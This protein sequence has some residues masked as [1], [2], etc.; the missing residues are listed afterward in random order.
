MSAAPKPSRAKLTHALPREYRTRLKTARFQFWT[1]AANKAI[2]IEANIGFRPVLRIC[3]DGLWRLDMTG[4]P[5]SGTVTIRT[6]AENG[7]DKRDAALTLDLDSYDCVIATDGATFRDGASWAFVTSHGFYDA[8]V[9]YQQCQTDNGQA[10]MLAEATALAKAMIFAV[11]EM[12]QKRVLIIT[13]CFSLIQVGDP[14]EMIRRMAQSHPNAGVPA[15]RLENA[16][17]HRLYTIDIAH[18][19]SHRSQESESYGPAQAWNNLADALAAITHSGLHRYSQL[20]AN[21]LEA[22]GLSELKSFKSRIE[23][24]YSLMS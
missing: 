3:P 20:F 2:N 1:D 10:S 19:R 9:V 7:R 8:A 4:A 17:R 24:R 12:S 22:V 15:K 11:E 18:V 23:V 16:L 14:V 13:D 21:H 6:H 5:K